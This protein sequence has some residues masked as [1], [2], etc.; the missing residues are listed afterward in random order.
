MSYTGSPGPTAPVTIPNL[1]PATLPLAETDLIV[2]A[3]SGIARQTSALNV[4]ALA[5]VAGP[6]AQR[7]LLPPDGAIYF[8]TTL[9]LPIWAL[10]TSV[11]G[12]VNAAGVA[13]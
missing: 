7:P 13:V 4:A 2:V 3:Q 5:V 9:G 6:T 11:T 12:W 1:A 10:G 8:D